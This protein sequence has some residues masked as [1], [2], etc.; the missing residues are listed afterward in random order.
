VIY[1]WDEATSSIYLIYVYS[2]ADVGDLTQSQLRDL[3]RL[4]REELK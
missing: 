3:A 4:V 2:K 1:Y